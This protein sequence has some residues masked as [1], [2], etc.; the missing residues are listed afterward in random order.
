MSDALH[1]ECDAIYSD[2][3]VA[4]DKL[5]ENVHPN[6]VNHLKGKAYAELGLTHA[7]SGANRAHSGRIAEGRAWV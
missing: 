7:L 6:A 5:K 4:C 2:H 3:G 1:D